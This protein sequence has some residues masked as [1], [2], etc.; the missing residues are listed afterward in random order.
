MSSSSKDRYLEA[1]RRLKEAG[2]PIS[3][4]RVALEAGNASGS[5]RKTRY[6]DVCEEVERAIAEQKSAKKL[7]LKNKSSDQHYKDLEYQTGSYRAQTVMQAGLIVSLE[8]QLFEVTKELED[9]K[10][11]LQDLEEK[12]AGKVTKINTRL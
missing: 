9:L 10:N 2:M 5:L 11:E 8:N 3:L 4:N 7:K 6:P 12:S 1:L